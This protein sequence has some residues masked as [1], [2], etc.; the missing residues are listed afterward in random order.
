MEVI[1][2]RDIEKS[3]KKSRLF[4]KTT[5]HSDYSNLDKYL[6]MCDHIKDEAKK[7]EYWAFNL[8]EPLRSKLLYT[9]GQSSYGHRHQKLLIYESSNLLNNVSPTHS[10]GDVRTTSDNYCEFKTSYSS[11]EGRY[12]FLQVRLWQNLDGYIFKAIDRY[13]NF[14][15]KYFC[16]TRQ[17]IDEELSI[18]KPKATHGDRRVAAENKRV[19]LSFR[20]DP[21]NDDERNRWENLYLQEDVFS[22]LKSL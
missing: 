8:E 20:Y 3:V 2:K 17:Q 21:Y 6:N 10:R 9:L 15:I 5:T 19:E 13:D 11:K 1:M 18:Q 14:S 16:F 7:D 12:C 22:W 4:L